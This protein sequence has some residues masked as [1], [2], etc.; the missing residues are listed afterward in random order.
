MWVGIGIAGFIVLVLLLLSV[1][2]DLAMRLEFYGKPDLHLKWAWLFG[3]VSKGIEA[4]KRHVSKKKP[5]KKHKF[6]ITRTLSRVRIAADYMR[7]EG[8]IQQ[9]ALF[10]KRVFLRIHVQKLEGE[11]YAG[12]EDPAET[13]YIFFTLIQ[14]INLLLSESLPCSMAILPSWVGPT[15]E[16]RI[17]AELRV[18]PIRLA[19]PLLQL[20][21]SRT[22][23][24]TIKTTV[25]LRWKRKQ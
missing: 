5:E 20:L 24:R 11:F 23:F 6:D 15:F 13:S 8:L 9:L 19:G 1:P 4:S 7:I 16:G 14:P 2:F 3:L 21:F 10:M 18:Y 17:R 22:A 25:L 12:L